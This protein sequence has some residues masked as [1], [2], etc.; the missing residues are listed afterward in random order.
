MSDT[1]LRLIRIGF[2]S[3][4]NYSPRYEKTV[5]L[6]MNRPDSTALERIEAVQQAYL[7]RCPPF[8]GYDGETYPQWRIVQ[9]PI[10]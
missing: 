9:D 1:I 10:L 8:R 5:G 2:D 6:F 4:E 7:V 3:L